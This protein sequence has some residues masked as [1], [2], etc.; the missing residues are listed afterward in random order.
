MKKFFS[1]FILLLA[2]VAL[3]ACGGVEII[4]TPPVLNGVQTNVSVE[5]GSDYDPLAGITAT[6]TLDGNLTSEIEII[7]FQSSWLD[8]PGTRTYIVRVED[9]EGEPT[10]VTVTLVITASTATTTGAPTTTVTGT[11]TGDSTTVTTVITTA[12]PVN[13]E[14]YFV[15]LRERQTYYIGSLPY[16]P[17]EGVQAL[18]AEDGDLTANID[19]IGSYFSNRPG[20]Y[21]LIFEV[22]DETGYVISKTVSLTVKEAVTLPTELTTDPVTIT[23]WHS[24]G[25]TIEQALNDYANEFELLYPNITVTIVKNGDNYDMLRQ[26]VVRAIQGSELPNIVQNYPDH[27]MEYLDNSAIVSL[28]PYIASPTWGYNPDVEEESFADILENYR[29]ENSQYTIDGEFFSLPYNKSTEVLIY[30]KTLIDDL[31]ADGVITEL[32]ST[33]QG[34]FA[35]TDE[36]MERKDTMIDTLMERLNASNL[37]AHHKTVEEIQGIK[38]TF[39]PFSYDASDNAFIT[40]TRQWGGQYTAINSERQ[41]LILFDNPQ[42]RNMLQFV[43]ENRDIFTTPEYWDS[44][45]A[46]DMF[47]IGQTAITIGSTGGARYNTPNVVQYANGDME[48]SID[49]GMAPMPYNADMP[50]NRT[51]IQQG[52]NLSIMNDPAFTDQQKLASWLFLKYLTSKEVQMDFAIRTG[53]SP[54]RYSVYEEQAYQS[55]ISDGTALPNYAAIKAGT[56]TNDEKLETATLATEQ[57]VRALGSAAATAQREY[58]FYDQA[59]VGSSTARDAVEVAYQRVVLALPTADMMTEINGAIAAAKA[60]AE[61][62]LGN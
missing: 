51:V 59:F 47:K 48:S 29:A 58:L 24:N 53:Y 11:N 10:E 62:V 27:V 50:E 17:L 38:E 57:M 7:G 33:W 44:G 12:P 21:T 19:I 1:L 43:F 9:S 16:D 40:L 2:I 15:G 42:V 55:F 28:T 20:K 18:D 13:T 49:I 25:S 39:V 5:V 56:G 22:E 14:P 36:I 52:T 32:P 6:D 35:L 37:T 41:G 8:R 45:Y 30:N 46:S 60:E 31:F 54:V 23:L 26:N 3:T 34:W 61:K 4:N